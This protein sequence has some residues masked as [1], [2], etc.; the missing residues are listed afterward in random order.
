M[1]PFRNKDLPKLTQII[2]L[3]TEIGNRY[4]KSPTQVA[5]RWLIQPGPYLPH[6][7]Q[8]YVTLTKLFLRADIA[9]IWLTEINSLILSLVIIL[10]IFIPD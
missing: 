3:L 5:L 2:T 7:R 6:G 10:P 4:S 8:G 1:R 9:N